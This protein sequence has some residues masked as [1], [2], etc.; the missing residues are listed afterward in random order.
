MLQISRDDIIADEIVKY[1]K[2]FIQLNLE[3]YMG[4]MGMTPISSQMAI[5]NALNNPKYRFVTAAVSRRQG[6][7]HIANIVAQLVTLVPGSSV[8]IMS[9]NYS[10]STISFEIQRKLIKQFDLNVVRDNAKDKIIELENGSEIRMGSVNQVDACVGRSYNF[11]IFDEAAL[12]EG[13]EAFSQSLRPTLDKDNSKA[14]FI[15]TPRGRNNW[16]SVLFDRG[17]SSAYPQWASIRA[18]WHE[19]PRTSEKDIDEAKRSMSEALFRQEYLADFTVYEGQIWPYTSEC[20]VPEIPDLDAWDIF[21]GLDVGFRDPTAFVV[22]AYNHKTK[23]FYLVDEYFNTAQSTETHAKEINLLIDKWNID[24]IFI[25][26]AAAQTRF[27]L[28][29]SYDIGTTNAKKSLRDGVAHISALLEN[30]RLF[31]HDGL[32]EVQYAFDQY[33]WDPNPNLINEKPL[34][35]RASHMADAIRYGLYSF[36]ENAGIY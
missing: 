34:H 32:R 10:L 36:T 29:D 20:L 18:T 27:D 7:T 31:V 6:K 12:T 33:Q 25:D 14:L 9:P 22:C 23:E 24:T 17:F 3:T 11:I 26:S 16:F 13:M 2:P 28:A 8:L 1:D 21:A 4:M 15:S 30:E 19:N 5:V 35:N